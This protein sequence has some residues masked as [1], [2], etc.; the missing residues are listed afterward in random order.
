MDV[1]CLLEGLFLSLP[2]YTSLASV[3][4]FHDVAPVLI[5]S[6]RVGQDHAVRQ[7]WRVQ[8]RALVCDRQPVPAYAVCQPGMDFYLQAWTRGDLPILDTT[9]CTI[10]PL[11]SGITSVS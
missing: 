11:L 6:D 10:A 3:D 8:N 4:D 9:S 2:R 5:A 1:R 7:T